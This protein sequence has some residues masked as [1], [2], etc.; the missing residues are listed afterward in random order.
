MADFL[1][2]DHYGFTFTVE[3]GIDAL[4]DLIWHLESYEQVGPFATGYARRSCR[5]ARA[6]RT[7]ARPS[8]CLFVLPVELDVASTNA[9]IS[10]AAVD[11]QQ[12][13][14]MLGF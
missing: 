7:F 14:L 2:T 9:G 1:G 6:R 8:P 11:F 13:F 3:E 4:E 12:T 5:A 10:T